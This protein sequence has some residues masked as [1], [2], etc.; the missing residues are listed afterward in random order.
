MG[1]LAVTL[2]IM[3]KAPAGVPVD[4]LGPVPIAFRLQGPGK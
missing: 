1:Q 2:N 4:R 3:R